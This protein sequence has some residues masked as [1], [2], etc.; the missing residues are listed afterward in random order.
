MSYEE[1]KQRRLRRKK[2]RNLFVLSIFVLLVARSAYGI[3]VK[4][5]KTV[6]PKAEEYRM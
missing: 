4:N 2:R 5:P 3:L 1:R 6:L